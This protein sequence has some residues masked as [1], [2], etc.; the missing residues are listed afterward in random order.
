PRDV[1]LPV[2]VYPRPEVGPAHFRR[3]GPERLQQRIDDGQLAPDFG[4]SQLH[5]TAGG[6]IVGARRPLIAFNVN[7]R[8]DVGVAREVAS[9]VREPGG[10]FPGVRALGRALPRA[11]LAQSSTP[12]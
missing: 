12:G 6:V 3:G 4:P 7:L 11:G 1:E 9:L 10:G 2:F 5:P 8:G